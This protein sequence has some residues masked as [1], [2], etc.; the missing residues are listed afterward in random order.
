MELAIDVFAVKRKEFICVRLSWHA[1]DGEVPYHLDRA[2]L[3]LM[4]MEIGRAEF[5]I[6]IGDLSADPSLDDIVPRLIWPGDIAL[7]RVLAFRRTA[8][9]EDTGKAQDTKDSITHRQPLLSVPCASSSRLS[10]ILKSSS[11]KQ[12]NVTSRRQVGFPANSRVAVI[13]ILAASSNG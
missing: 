2:I 13:A 8:R 1:I 6:E 7:R 10:Y 5:H 4:R 12:Q 3:H 11:E 9:Q